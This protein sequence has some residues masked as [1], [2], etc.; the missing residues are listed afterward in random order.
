MAAERSLHK[1]CGMGLSIPLDQFSYLIADDRLVY[2][3]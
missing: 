2:L 1:A 3:T